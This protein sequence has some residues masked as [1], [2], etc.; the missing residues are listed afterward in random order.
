MS[1]SLSQSNAFRNNTIEVSLLECLEK[2]H[3]AFDQ[4]QNNPTETDSAAGKVAGKLQDRAYRIF[5]RRRA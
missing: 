1:K 3:Y 4:L 5:Q 2:E